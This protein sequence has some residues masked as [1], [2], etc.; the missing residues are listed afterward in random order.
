MTKSR[1][2]T[3]KL[4]LL[5]AGM[6]GF[7][8]A[9]VPIYSL[10]CQVTGLGGRTGGLYVYDPAVVKPDVSRV[11]EVTFLT[12]TNDGM[13][14]TFRAEVNGLRVHPGEL[15]EAKFYVR[16]TTDRTMVAQA[17]PSLAP[18]NAAAYF[19]KTECFCFARQVLAPGEELEMPMR[20]FVAPEVPRNVESVSLSYT[21]FDVTQLAADGLIDSGA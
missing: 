5:V 12:N 4:V 17:V 14:W 10:L 1:A 19:H 6:F 2:T 7:G 13:P 21:L 18:G 9:L 15:A 11:V 8:F 16:N 3:W 20:F